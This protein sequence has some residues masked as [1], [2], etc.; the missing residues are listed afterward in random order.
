MTSEL[1]TERRDGTLVL[2]LSDPASRNG[3]SEQVFAAGIEALNVA[4]SDPA[5]RAIVLR[6]DGDHFCAG[7]E[8]PALDPD[9]PA[10]SL[11]HFQAFVEALHVCP[12]PVIAA[13]EGDAIAGGFAL[14]LACDLLVAAAD[15][16]LLLSDPRAGQQADAGATARM[17]RHLPRARVL[18]WLW[19][20][21]PVPVQQLQA[22]GIVTRVS[23]HGEAFDQALGLAA[24]LAD[25]D[26]DAVAGAKELVNPLAGDIA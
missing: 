2:T 19:L 6:G 23:G 17:L 24:R 20:G 21:E 1:H 26:P 9:E 11:Q 14:A 3:L 12:K 7:I 13:V 4:E 8:P 5:V 10:P 16:R 15:A 25:V 22:L 18:Q